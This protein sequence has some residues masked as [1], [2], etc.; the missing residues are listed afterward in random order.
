[1]KKVI[2]DKDITGHHLEYIHHLYMGM[3]ERQTVQYVMIIPETFKEESTKYQWPQTSNVSFDFLS[4]EEL[5]AAA[6]G[7]ALISAWKNA[8]IIRKRIKV[9]Q[10]DALFLIDLMAFLPFILLILPSKVKISG[11][12]YHIYLYRWKQMNRIMKAKNVIL[13]WLLAH[14]R[15]TE[16]VFMLNDH[17]ASAYLNKRYHTDRFA[18]LPDPFNKIDYQPKNVREALGIG[19]ES[20]VFLHFGG[21]AKRKGTITILEAV[22]EISPE[23]RKKITLVFAGKVYP[24]IHDTFYRLVEELKS[25]IQIITYDYFCSNE[26]LADLCYTADFL[27]APYEAVDL[28][29]GVIGYA[30][31][32]NKPVIGPSGGLLGKIIRRYQLGTALQDITPSSMAK[33]IASA[34]PYLIES[35]YKEKTER[36]RFTER[37][38][39]L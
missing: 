18:F 38:L 5:D 17:S 35:D 14:A 22:R 1:M 6:S 34:E 12:I 19:K 3:V 16:K 11:I 30:A 24:D 32:Y 10:P 13:Y 7:N 9:H 39:D 23:Q 20:R 29:S 4:K 26:L 31:Y 28:S 21:L 37:I 2:F 33:A 8:L 15:S 36:E 25:S 27:L